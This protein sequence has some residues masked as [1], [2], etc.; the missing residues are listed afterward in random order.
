MKHLPT[1]IL[2]FSNFKKLILSHYFFGME[3]K[4]WKP[5]LHQNIC[6]GTGPG[7]KKNYAAFITFN[8]KV[9]IMSFYF[10]LVNL[11]VF[12]ELSVFRTTAF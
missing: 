5:E 9:H 2:T 10:I 1:P 3:T 8:V 11:P 4:P 6:M 7:M 12:S